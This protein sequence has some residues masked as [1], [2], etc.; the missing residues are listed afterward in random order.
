VKLASLQ[1][2]KEIVWIFLRK[3]F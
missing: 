3:K 1:Y 2:K